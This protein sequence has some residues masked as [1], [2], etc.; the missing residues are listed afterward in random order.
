M[1]DEQPQKPTSLPEPAASSEDT[2]P[3]KLSED[4]TPVEIAP[5]DDDT[6]PTRPDRHDASIIPPPPKP[7]RPATS[8]RPPRKRAPQRN[9]LQTWLGVMGIVG[10]VGLVVL[11]VLFVVFLLFAPSDYVDPWVPGRLATRTADA[12][13]AE[14]TAALLGTRQAEIAMTAT[15]VAVDASRRETL[16]AESAAQ[17][18]TRGAL[19]LAGTAAALEQAATSGALDLDA[20]RTA[21][22][23]SAQQ[24]AAAATLN[25]IDLLFTQTAVA[26]STRVALQPTGTP[27][28][29]ISP[30]SSSLE[31]GAAALPTLDAAFDTFFMDDF[32][33][34]FNNAWNADPA[35]GTADGRAFTTVCGA[36]LTIGRRDWTGFAVEADIDNPGAQVA[37]TFGYGDAGTLYVNLGLDGALWWLVENAPLID[38]EL[39]NNLYN[40]ATVNRVRVVADARVVSVYMNGDVIAERLLPTTVTGP[41]GLYACP[42]N[43]VIP[44]FDNLRVLRL[45]E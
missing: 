25:A 43:R 35:W 15:A 20:T 6:H 19:D 38:T 41:V 39:T 14:Q 40:P 23:L 9:P 1:T 34:G 37:L 10:L 4:T 42:A 2:N 31:A 36:T 32:N 3:A 33:D 28:G 7:V 45:T 12:V 27:S 44:R 16:S 24:T 11:L 17:A 21:G 29:G 30:T 26:V 18:V 22:A 8:V 5:A 13:F